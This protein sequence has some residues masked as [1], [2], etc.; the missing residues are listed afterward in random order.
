MILRQTEND[1]VKLLRSQVNLSPYFFP[2]SS[3]DWLLGLNKLVAEDLGI[4]AILGRSGL[5]VAQTNGARVFP[6]SLSLGISALTDS[7]RGKGRRI[8]IGIPP[9]A[10]HLPLLLA[11]VSVLADTLRKAQAAAGHQQNTAMPGVLIVSTDLDVRSRYCD[12]RVKNETLDSVFPGSRMKPSGEVVALSASQ[13]NGLGKGVCFLLP[14]QKLPAAN[15]RVGLAVLDLRYARLSKRA[16]NIAT[17]ACGLHKQT[18][19]IALYTLGDRE[20]LDALSK[21]NFEVFPVDHSA[22]ALCCNLMPGSLPTQGAVDWNILRNPK[23]LEREHEVV[24][25]QDDTLEIMLATARKMIDEQKAEDN[26]GINRARWIAAA[27]TQLPTPLIWYEQAARNLGRSTLRRMIDLLSFKHEVG[28]GSTMQSLRMQFEAILNQIQTANPR[29]AKFLEILPNLVQDAGEV[30]VLVRDDISRRALQNWF[31]VEAFPNAPWLRNVSICACSDYSSI[32]LKKFPLVIVNGSFPRRYRWIA[33]AALGDTVNF[34]AFPSEVSVIESQLQDVYSASAIDARS[35]QRRRVL[36][37]P[38]SSKNEAASFTLHFNKPKTSAESAKKDASSP[39]TIKSLADIGKTI[40]AAK[41]IF[42]RKQ[43]DEK[44][45]QELKL[46]SWE[47]TATDD[48][49]ELSDSDTDLPAHTDDLNCHQFKIMSKQR[50]LGMLWLPPSQMIECVRSSSPEVVSRLTARE[51]KHRDHIVFV[52]E[53]ARGGLFERVVEL[54][55]DQ[56]ELQYLAAY[57]KQWE[58][59]IRCLGIKYDCE[60]RGYSQLLYDFRQAG[61]TIST[62]ISIGNWISGRVMGPDDVSSIRAAGQLAGMQSLQREAGDFDRAFRQ[63]RALH[64]ALGRRLTRL[65]KQSSKYL[66]DDEGST[67]QDSLG[68]HIWLPVNELLET[69]DVSEVLSVSTETQSIPP[70][71]V[72][73]FIPG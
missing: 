46:I 23:Y 38:A 67:G 34:L 37:V 72:G 55:E 69:V 17:W 6:D 28:M 32:A 40:E 25:I 12:L 54:A 24:S 29:A 33:G 26:F 3:P 9:G 47:D 51:V 31:D 66:M 2:V 42:T 60:R 14:G 8:A 48:A 21:Q 27:L 1:P 13:K 62:E 5:N 65:I 45:R 10:R 44:K 59:A 57:R 15:V 11:A 73:R 18:E 63:I 49:S 30:L 41:S 56:P 22:C 36:G 7:L 61:S 19:V 35:A 71:K 39:F 16:K 70:S 52:Q 50:G 53:D 43:E 58:E 4:L 68:D 64:Q 20:T